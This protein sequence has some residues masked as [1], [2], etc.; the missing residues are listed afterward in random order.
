MT[1]TGSPT[2]APTPV[3]REMFIKEGAVS[4]VKATIAMKEFAR[5]VQVECEEVALNLLYDIN[6]KMGTE[7][8]EESLSPYPQAGKL[9]DPND[10][11]LCVRFSVKDFGYMYL[12]LY[13]ELLRDGSYELHAV[14]TFEFSKKELYECAR[15]KFQGVS[16]M[17]DGFPYGAAGNCLTLSEPIPT[18]QAA[19]FPL[20]V[21]EV[22]SRFLEEWKRIGGL[23]G[24]KS[25]PNPYSPTASS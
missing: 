9:V 3:G 2:T 19:S 14:A 6:F 12:G 11:W 10:P 20:I 15:D 5:I 18:E 24:L 17:I 7:L 16:S 4:Y 21:D 13:W 8:T 22:F 1:T 23:N 25:P